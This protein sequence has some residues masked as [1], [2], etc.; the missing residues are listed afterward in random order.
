MTQYSRIVSLEASA[1]LKRISVVPDEAS[2]R[3]TALR[4]SARIKENTRLIFG[5]MLDE[6]LSSHNLFH[7]S[8]EATEST[9]ERAPFKMVC[10]CTNRLGITCAFGRSRLTRGLC[11]VQRHKVVLVYRALQLLWL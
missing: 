4:L 3:C 5:V 10:L 11:G 6:L 9:G 7:L 2:A 8:A 1:L